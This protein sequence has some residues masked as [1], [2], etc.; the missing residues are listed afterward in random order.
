MPI[1][2]GQANPDLAPAPVASDRVLRIHQQIHEDLLQVNR[3]A[4]HQD[5]IRWE[6]HE[7]LDLLIE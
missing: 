6:F 1:L 3:V 5:R 4:P 2:R 7:D